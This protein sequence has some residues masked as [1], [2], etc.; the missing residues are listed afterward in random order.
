MKTVYR[1][2]SVSRRCKMLMLKSVI[3]RTVLVWKCTLS[4]TLPLPSNY[5]TLPLPL[6]TPNP[7][8]RHN[9]ESCRQ[10]LL[11]RNRCV[12]FPLSKISRNLSRS[13]AAHRDGETSRAFYSNFLSIV[14]S[15][16]LPGKS[17]GPP[18]FLNGQTLPFFSCGFTYC[19]RLLWIWWSMLSYLVWYYF[20]P[21]VIVLV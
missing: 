4:F 7:P 18:F 10:R 9:V 20:Q 6:P 3:Y 8:V 17:P 1:V 21:N 12:I 13:G 11:K 16:G 15:P 2:R 14:S 19:V 5:P